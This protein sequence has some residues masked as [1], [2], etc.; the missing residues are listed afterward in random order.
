MSSSRT[1]FTSVITYVPPYTKSK[2]VEKLG[3]EANCNLVYRLPVIPM[4]MSLGFKYN[5]YKKL[6]IELDKALEYEHQYGVTATVEYYFD[7]AKAKDGNTTPVKP[8]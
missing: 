8:E 3:M 1:E 5:M 4:S 6:V 7:V 2:H